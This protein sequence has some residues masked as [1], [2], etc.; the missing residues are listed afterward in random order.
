MQSLVKL[1]ST[2][3]ILVGHISFTH[4]GNFARVRGAEKPSCSFGQAR[5]NL[6]ALPGDRRPVDAISFSSLSDRGIASEGTVLQLKTIVFAE[7]VVDQDLPKI[8]TF[9]NRWNAWRAL[10]KYAAVHGADLLTAIQDRKLFAGFAKYQPAYAKVVYASMVRLQ[11]SRLFT[12]IQFA[13]ELQES[14]AL[15]TRTQLVQ[16][17][18]QTPPI[19]TR[20]YS[21]I[22]K[23]LEAELSRCEAV[24]DKLIRYIEHSAGVW[25][26]ELPYPRALMEFVGAAYDCGHPRRNPAAGAVT[27][28]YAVCEANIGAHSGMRVGEIKLLPFA[29]VDSIVHHGVEHALILGVTTKNN[30]GEMKPDVWVTNRTGTRALNLMRKL[31]MAVYRVNGFDATSPSARLFPR[32]GIFSGDFDVNKHQVNVQTARLALHKR[33]S[34]IICEEDVLELERYDNDRNWRD[35]HVFTVG[36]PW[37]LANHQLRRSLALY[38]HGSGL[39]QIPELKAQLKQITDEMAFFYAS[40]STAVHSLKFD[41]DHIAV[42]WRNNRHLSEFF[43]YQQE[44]LFGMKDTWGGA[45]AWAKSPGVQ[46]SS[47]SVM[48]RGEAMQMFKRGELAYK[49][50]ITGGCTTTG[51]CKLRPLNVISVECIRKNCKDLVVVQEKLALAIAAQKAVVTRLQEQQPETAEYRFEQEILSVLKTAYEEHATP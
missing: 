5:W 19:P 38:A 45:V 28:I 9:Y 3:T 18:K 27:E 21:A 37:T 29:C 8:G 30:K 14:C 34:P 25:P 42:E 16:N 36:Q 26:N 50:T 2:N 10:A 33:V 47:V 23:G 20:I 39:V 44:V 12:N 24:A 51:E 31:V 1:Y 17:E 46:R 48:A 13:V 35:E 22:L 32:H 7:Q 4:P 41:K 40:G 15:W 43:A 11:N 49:E 6:N